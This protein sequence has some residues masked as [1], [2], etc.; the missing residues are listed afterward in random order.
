MKNN[1]ALLRS[2]RAYLLRCDSELDPMLVDDFLHDTSFVCLAAVFENKLVAAMQAFKMKQAK[3][4]VAVPAPALLAIAA[5]VTPP[6]TPPA[7]ESLPECAAASTTVIAAATPIDPSGDPVPP[8]PKTPPAEVPRSVLTF[9]L[10]NARVGEAYAQHPTPT[11]PLPV[12]IVYLAIGVP[13]ELGLT[14]DLTS[15]VI[16]GTPQAA[17]EFDLTILFHFAGEATP[18]PQTASVP[19][20]VNQDPKLMWKNLPSDRA[21]PYWKPDEQCDIV[22]APG[23]RLV[24]ASKRGRSHAHVGSF[25]DDDYLIDYL[26]ASGW[27]IAVVA[28]GAGSAKYSRRGAQ[29]VCQQAAAH[30]KRS[31]DGEVGADVASAAE[32]FHNARSGTDAAR[33]DAA[34]QLLHNHLVVTVGH[35][36]HHAVK[37]IYAELLVHLELNASHKDFSSTAIIT[38]SRRFPF[39]TLCVAYWVGDGAVGVYRQNGDIT[40]L[41]DVDSGEFSGQTR[42]LDNNEVTAAAL[43]QRT[44]F[45]L[46]DDM[47]A[48]VLMTDGVSDA[49]FDTEA[50]LSRKPKWDALWQEIDDAVG[51]TGAAEGLEQ[52]LLSWLDFWSQGNHDDRT[53]ALLLQEK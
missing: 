9:R 44:R 39:G 22:T 32:A 53:I 15:G 20:L 35:A 50:N 5:P 25:R 24:A 16:A 26:P 23:F 4:V 8:T 45:A 2:C 30:L 38:A 1:D 33:I 12:A 10:P 51:L 43:S 21:A 19:L 40:L 28:D 42:F 6:A 3:P 13:P 18:H 14:V 34:R 36:A 52:R 17:G 11:T 46:V 49:K 48:L 31:L 47:T 27:M 37:A 29:I 41:G 7:S